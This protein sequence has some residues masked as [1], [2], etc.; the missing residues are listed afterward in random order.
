MTTQDRI[1]SLRLPYSDCC[2]AIDGARVLAKLTDRPHVLYMTVDELSRQWHVLPE[3]EPAP[4]RFIECWGVYRDSD[5]RSGIAQDP[6]LTPERYAERTSPT[7]TK[8]R[9][10]SVQTRFNHYINTVQD[11]HADR[12]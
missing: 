12:E 8:T 10:F 6:S 5:D 11:K 1:K 4:T 9:N 3:G 2:A 7:P